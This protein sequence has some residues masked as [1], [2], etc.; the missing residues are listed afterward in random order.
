[1]QENVGENNNEGEEGITV[2]KTIP[3][4]LCCA[5]MYEL[6]DGGSMVIHEDVEQPEPPLLALE[7]GIYIHICTLLKVG[8]HCC[9]QMKNKMEFQ[10]GSLSNQVPLVVW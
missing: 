3:Y 4:G 9:L 5:G 6:E 10:G 7:E 8:F 2:V 1:M